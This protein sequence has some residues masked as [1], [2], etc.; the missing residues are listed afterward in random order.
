MAAKEQE[1][2]S[3]LAS[4]DFID[5]PGR[6]ADWYSS[7]L[8]RCLSRAV[9]NA[10]T[11]GVNTRSEWRKILS[12]YTQPIT[13]ADLSRARHKFQNHLTHRLLTVP[14]FNVSVENRVRLKMSRWRLCIP[15]GIVTRRIL[16]RLP[17]IGKLVNPRVHAA[18]FKAVWNGWT[19]S[20]RFQNRS[21]C[22]LG[23][24]EAVD[25]LG[26]PI[27]EDRIEHY[28]TCPF[29]CWLL[30]KVGLHPSHASKEHF[31]LVADGMMEHTDR[32]VLRSIILYAM[33]RATNHFRIHH[34]VSPVGV[35]HFLEEAC[36]AATRGHRSSSKTLSKGWATHLNVAVC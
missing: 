23:C 32:V 29:T 10:D 8:I 28:V 21:R 7:S 11:V 6:F 4:T 5:R 27:A 20:A 19:T 18:I 25:A 24:S 36:K 22:V 31:F 9:H 3:S 15:P 26:Y 17:S 33:M 16:D 34:P 1:L 2:Q 13:L 14:N 35:R 30:S 12:T